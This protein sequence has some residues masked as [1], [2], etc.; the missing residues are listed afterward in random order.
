[1]SGIPRI[2]RTYCVGM[3][4][5]TPVAR[6]RPLQ[7]GPERSMLES[8]LDFYRATVVN[9]V[10]GLTDAQASARRSRRPL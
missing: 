5:V 3:T 4:D 6:S 9:K 10:A 1:M 8:M 2:A 7:R